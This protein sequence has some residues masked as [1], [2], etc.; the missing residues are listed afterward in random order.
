MCVDTST[1]NHLELVTNELGKNEYTLY[2]ILNRTLTPGGD[3]FLRANILQPPCDI[4]TIMTRLDCIAELIEN[5]DLF[6]DLK[7]SRI[8]CS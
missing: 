5:E 1:A 6:N 8:I 2:G 3:R 7:V 4:N